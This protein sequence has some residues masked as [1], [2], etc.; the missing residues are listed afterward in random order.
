[1]AEPSKGYFLGFDFS[2]Q[3]LK[4]LAVDESLKVV[5]EEYVKFDTDLPEFKTNGGVHIHDNKV[6]I[7]SPTAMWIKALD[8]LLDKM[9][10][11]K[12]DFSKV[13]AL[14]GDG[15]Q[16]GSVYWKKGARNKLTSL[17][18]DQP[19]YDQLKDEFS[20]PE[21][22]IWMDASTTR[23]CRD[24]EA[25]VGGAM[26]LAEITGSRGFERF[27]GIQ[28]RKIYQTKQEAYENTERISLVSSFAASLF[29]G[30]YAPI[31]F[32]DGSGMN[33]LDIRTKS[34]SAE[35]LE[36]CAPGL[37]SKLGEPVPS[38][39]VIGN[40]SSY[41]VSRY[42]F[43]PDCKVVAFTGDNPASLAGLAARQG[44]IIVSLGSSDVIFLWLPSATPGLTGHILVNP[45]D[46]DSYMGLICFKNS[47]L[48]RE[49]MRDLYAEGSWEKFEELLKA[50]PK[51]N[52]GNIGIYFDT[53]EVQPVVMGTFRF[54]ES[55]EQV[56]TF[57][58]ESEVR[59]VLES[60]FMARLAYAR[61][62]G[63]KIGPDARV[64][65]TGGASVNKAILQVIADI[66]NSSV[67]VTD[68]PNSAALGGCYRAK[69]AWQGVGTPFTDVVKNHPD[70]VC[71]AS[72]TPGVEKIYDLLQARYEK[73]EEM[74]ATNYENKLD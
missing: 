69:H 74:I 45:L 17:S 22:P 68:V 24:V 56:E 3:Q 18:P 39:Q 47:S 38:H 57:S 71:V 40:I 64:I 10:K 70:P 12:F 2:T 25:A 1:M 15:Q 37:A 50:A 19:L 59:A 13:V 27:T 35:V 41:L 63:L 61:K 42:N 44:D 72:H 65:A 43:S 7:T 4:A 14:S 32:S 33:L 48:T 54:N 51:G 16:H 53:A 8:L 5:L 30:D 23:Q 36:A 6:T 58:N 9:K 60:Q 28:I 52:H 62:C 34:W 46:P 26:V 20:I 67:Y 49:K 11:S 31:D 73:L 21:S 29:I 55:D 66:F